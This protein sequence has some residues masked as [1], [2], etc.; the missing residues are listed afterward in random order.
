[1]FHLLEY[2]KFIA[3][4]YGLSLFYWKNR[5]RLPFK[6]LKSSTKYNHSQ[7]PPRPYPTTIQHTT[8][9]PALAQNRTF[10]DIYTVHEKLRT[11]GLYDEEM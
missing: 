8:P 1:M 10:R 4:Y 6:W 5:L 2:S 11:E 3:G 9:E 7:Q